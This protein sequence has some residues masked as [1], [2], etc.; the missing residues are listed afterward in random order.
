MAFGI[1]F[2]MRLLLSLGVR[3]LATSVRGWNSELHN[4]TIVLLLP[5]SAFAFV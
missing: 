4:I 3:E 5:G 1:G 2:G